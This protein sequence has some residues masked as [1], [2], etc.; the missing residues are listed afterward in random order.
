M[1]SNVR[2]VLVETTH[3]GNIGAVARAMKN[4]GLITLYLVAPKK[5]PSADATARA[6]GADDVLA[7]AVIC[8]TLFEAIGDCH[9]VIGTS[10]RS[11]TIQWP[12]LDPRACAEKIWAEPDSTQIAILF[13]REH[14]GLTN[15]E[16]DCCH[17]LLKIPCNPDFSSLNVAAAVQIIAYEIFMAAARSA[18]PCL[19]EQLESPLATALELESFYQHLH[20]TLAEIRFLH[21]GRSRSVMRRLRRLFNRVRLEKKEVDI[22]R[23]ILSAAQGKKQ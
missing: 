2:I 22:L 9:L 4:M 6:S 8:K 10:A 12:M 3:P 14:S 20:Q 7:S 19:E 23:G 21:L 17:Y 18:K 5:F 13:G 16:L 11:R 15:E 1:L